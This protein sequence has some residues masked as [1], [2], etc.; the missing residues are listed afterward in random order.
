MVIIIIN[1]DSWKKKTV[2]GTVPLCSQLNI[3]Y[4]TT[5]TNSR[6]FRTVESERDEHFR[7]L[8]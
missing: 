5:Y 4:C 7:G 8:K 1:A 6:Y 3:W 2:I